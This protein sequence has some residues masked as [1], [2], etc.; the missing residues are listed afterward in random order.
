MCTCNTA[1][2]R[3]ASMQGSIKETGKLQQIVEDTIPHPT[4]SKHDIVHIRLWHCCETKSCTTM[5]MSYIQTH[6]ISSIH[7]VP[8]TQ[9]Y[10][11]VHELSVRLSLSLSLSHSHTHTQNNNK[12][13]FCLTNH[14]AIN[15]YTNKTPMNTHKMEQ[16]PATLSGHSNAEQTLRLFYEVTL[17]KHCGGKGQPSKREHSPQ[18][19]GCVVQYECM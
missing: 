13:P 5:Y 9:V 10:I 11:H 19:G 16:Q 8:H 12:N 17:R 7:P 3:A 2:H 6:I 15:G 14:P 1:I 4:G 18:N